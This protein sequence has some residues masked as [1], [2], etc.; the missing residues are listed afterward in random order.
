MTKRWDIKTTSWASKLALLQSSPQNV[1]E[2]NPVSSFNIAFLIFLTPALVVIYSIGL[3]SSIYTIRSIME[4]SSNQA[5][6]D[7][8]TKLYTLFFILLSLGNNS[9]SV[10]EVTFSSTGFLVVLN[11]PAYLTK[12]AVTE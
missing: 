8:L 1:N 9:I 4:F 5:I 12:A 6:S 7:I 10:F 3:I 2:I 11:F